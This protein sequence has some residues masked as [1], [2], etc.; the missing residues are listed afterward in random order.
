M[1][2]VPPDTYYMGINKIIYATA[3][4]L[5]D[6]EA[7]EYLLDWCQ[8]FKANLHILHI[9]KEANKKEAKNKMTLLMD[10]FQE[11]QKVGIIKTQLMQGNIKPVME[12]YLDFSHTDILAVHH[13]DEG[14]WQKIK[15]GSLTKILAEDT[16]IPLLVLKTN[17]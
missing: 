7:I 17:H 6:K 2:L 1:L 16:E 15:E 5:G 4:K 11:E 14:F 10:D 3:F 13:R 8:A 9:H 12:Q